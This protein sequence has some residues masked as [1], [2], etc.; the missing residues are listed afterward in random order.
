LDERSSNFCLFIFSLLS[1]LKQYRKYHVGRHTAAHPV[2]NVDF[3]TVPTI[4]KFVGAVGAWGQDSQG[5]HLVP[6]KISRS[7]FAAATR[8]SRKIYELESRYRPRTDLNFQRRDGEANRSWVSIYRR[9]R[10]RF[11]DRDRGF[12]EIVFGA[13]HRSRSVAYGRDS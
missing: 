8:R 3:S 10:R 6:N 1:I 7:Y 9:A 2:P 4:P 13:G 5:P 12:G 11:R